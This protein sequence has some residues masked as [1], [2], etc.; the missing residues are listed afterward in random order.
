MIAPG[1]DPDL[2]LWD[3]AVER[4]ITIDDLHHDGDHSPWEGWR[5]QG[6]PVV[7]ILRGAVV[8]EDGALAVEPGFGRFVPRKLEPDVLERPMF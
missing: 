5:V 6:W 2:V 3:P 1:S 4:T 7:T 8:V